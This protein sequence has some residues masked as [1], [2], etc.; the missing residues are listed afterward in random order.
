MIKNALGYELLFYVITLRS[1][2]KYRIYFRF[3]YRI[4]FYFL[5]LSFPTFENVRL[6]RK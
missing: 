4:L 1:S 3:C 5:L 6:S 2:D